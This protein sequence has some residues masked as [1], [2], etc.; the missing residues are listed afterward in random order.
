MAP[1]SAKYT[2]CPDAVPFLYGP[3]DIAVRTLCCAWNVQYVQ[4]VFASSENTAPLSLPTKTRPPTTAGWARA[5]LTPAK[6][7]AHFS[8]SFGTAAAE[9]L[10]LSAG[11]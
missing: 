5:E 7:N 9:S 8:V 6:P 11:A 1:P 4:P 3:T 10:P 2:A